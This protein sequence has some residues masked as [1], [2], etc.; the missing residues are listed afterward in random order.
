MTTL[1]PPRGVTEV[2]APAGSPAPSRDGHGSWWRRGIGVISIV[3]IV[4]ALGL[5]AWTVR[6]SHRTLDTTRQDLAVAGATRAELNDSLDTTNAELGSTYATLLGRNVERDD[7]AAALHAVQDD[8]LSANIRQLATGE[9][10]AATESQI[11]TLGACLSGVRRAIATVDAGAAVP[12]L[13]AAQPACTEAL[14]AGTGAVFPFDFPDPSVLRVGEA[15]FAFSTNAGVGD[16]QVIVSTDLVRWTIVGNALA[17]LPSWA[18]EGKTWAPAVAPVSGGYAL[19]YTARERSSGLQ[20]ISSAFSPTPYGPYVDFSKGPMLCQRALGGSIDPSPFIDAAG[21]RTL[22]WKSERPAEIWSQPL[23]ANGTLTGR[24]VRLL[25]VD[26]SWERGVVEAPSMIF[27]DGGF[28]LLYSGNRWARPDYATGAARCATPAGPCTKLAP[29]PIL[30]SYGQ[31]AG[32]GGAAL[33]GAASG[34]T[35]IAYAAYHQPS[36]GYPAS[37][38]LHLA[39]IDLGSSPPV[40]TP[41]P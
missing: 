30:T 20:C 21:S 25:G 5:L 18:D 40:V 32:P 3:T 31:I 36:V 34:E 2:S 28:T 6:R 26:Q 10:S 33:F 14:V 16:V 23:A 15:Y 39:T 4:I 12:E 8:L 35:Y 7:S 19:Y 29:G 11:A 9:L 17:G 27:G 38:L 1:T 22:L 41:I 13:R 37:R 24:A